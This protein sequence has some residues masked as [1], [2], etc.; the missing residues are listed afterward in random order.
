MALVVMQSVFCKWA[1]FCDD[2]GHWILVTKGMRKWWGNACLTPVKEVNCLPDGQICIL[3]LHEFAHRSGSPDPSGGREILLFLPVTTFEMKN[4]F[5]ASS[6]RWQAQHTE[7]VWHRA[8]S[9][10]GSSWCCSA[11]VHDQNIIHINGKLCQYFISLPS[12]EAVVLFWML[13]IVHGIIAICIFN[14][15]LSHLQG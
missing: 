5:V 3:F 6:S 12:G 10:R 15:W 8:T 11:C 4:V 13:F 9:A 1:T 7:L 14:Q 2:W